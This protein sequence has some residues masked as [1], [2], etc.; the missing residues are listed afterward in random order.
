MSKMQ[1]GAK[2]EASEEAHS[3]CDVANLALLLCEDSA[4]FQS[5]S[6]QYHWLRVFSDDSAQALPPFDK[7]RVAA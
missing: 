6:F 4:M 1:R 2:V 7:R 5:N 3:Q